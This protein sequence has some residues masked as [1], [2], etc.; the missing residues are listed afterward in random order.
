LREV[1]RPLLPASVLAAESFTPTACEDVVPP[2]LAW[3]LMNVELWYRIFVDRDPYWVAQ[4]T[5]LT[6][7]PLA[8]RADRTDAG[9]LF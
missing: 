3:Q 9:A 2:A 7:S 8:G 4:A 6:T 1:V 5:A